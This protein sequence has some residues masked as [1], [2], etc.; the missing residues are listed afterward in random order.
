MLVCSERV[1]YTTRSIRIYFYR[2]SISFCFVLCCARCMFMLLV[3]G[4]SIRSLPNWN[5]LNV[6]KCYLCA[7]HPQ[8]FFN[9][10]TSSYTVH[11]LPL[12]QNNYNSNRSTYNEKRV[13]NKMRMKMSERSKSMEKAAH[14]NA[15]SP[16]FSIARNPSLNYILHIY[17]ASVSNCIVKNAIY[18]FLKERKKILSL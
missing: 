11:L 12:H 2:F 4:L 18:L 8:S 7:V 1:L 10:V 17:S 9:W 14:S 16:A 15:F 5:L 3:F 13:P 6:I